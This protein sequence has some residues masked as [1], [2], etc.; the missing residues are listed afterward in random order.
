MTSILVLIA[1]AFNICLLEESQR[2]VVRILYSKM[3]FSTCRVIFV[4]KVFNLKFFQSLI[5]S[6]FSKLCEQGYFADLAYRPGSV[7][8]LHY[9][10]YVLFDA[11]TM[12]E[13]HFASTILCT[14]GPTISSIFIVQRVLEHCT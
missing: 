13:R 9:D 5:I 6:W 11:T 4:Q 10:P 7:L 12:V 2:R 14:A 8:F 1:F 3:S